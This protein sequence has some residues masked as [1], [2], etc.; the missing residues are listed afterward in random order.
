[1]AVEAVLA[2][3]GIGK[4]FPGVTALD[5]V[6]FDC[7]PGEIHGLVGENGAGKS[8]LMRILAGV[9]PPDAGRILLRGEE[10][11][12][13]GPAEAH[14]LGIAMVYQDTR[15]VPDLD[16]A[17]NIFLGHE[18]GGRLLVDRS[19]MRLRTAAILRRLGLDLDPATRVGDLGLA[20][21]QLVEIGR[22]LAVEAPVLILDEP[23]SSLTPPEVLRLFA[24][25]RELRAEGRSLV[26]ISHRLPEV[27]GLTDRI[28]VLKDG[29]VVATVP[30]AG[31]DAE[32][33]VRLMVGRDTS[34][35]YPPKATRAGPVRL[36]VDG[37]AAGGR[38]ADVRLAVRG[39]EIVGLGG[40]Q[41]SGQQDIA[42]ALGGVL[43]ATGT[44]TLDGRALT[45]R[46]PA[47][48]LAAGIIYVPADRRREGL[49]LPHAVREN[50]AAPHLGRWARL[51]LV[52]RATEA[53]AVARGIAGL[54]IRTPSPEQP[55]ATLSG[56]NQQK[57][58]FA[59]W[60]LAEPKV[61]ILD[62]PTQG[63]DVATKL[64]LY[65]Q[66][67]ALA[68]G[69][70][71][72]VVLSAD[73]LELMGLCDRILVVAR[74]R[75]VDDVPAA[76]ASEERIVGAAVKQADT[77]H[78]A[79]PVQRRRA[80]SPLR[81]R[82]A[83]VALLLLLIVALGAL[84]TSL[85]PWFLTP[86]NL[87]SLAM[88]VTPLALVALG[89]L[90]VILLGGIDL[91]VGPTISLVTA[92]ASFLL[93]S[94][95]GGGTA[96]G[97]AACLATGLAVGLGNA[98]LIRWLRI[99]DLVATLATYSI[100]FGLALIVRPSP[101]GSFDPALAGWITAKWGP[102]PVVAL[103]TLVLFLGLE[104]LLARGRLGPRLYATGGAREAAFVAGIAI[105][106][107]RVA[108]YLACGLFAALAGLV[109]AARI[110]SG[111]PQA[112]ISFTVTSITAVV[113]G[114]VGVAGGRGTALGTLL[115]CILVI[116]MQNVLNQ[117]HVS[118]YWQYVWTGGLLLLAVGVDALRERW[119]AVRG[120]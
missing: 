67:R 33:L 13:A 27:L 7:R 115:G 111:D 31:T 44:V 86:R 112:G 78:G 76:E 5:G 52:D 46:Q 37:L 48:A 98:V 3:E 68:E 30:T 22:A 90:L 17:A 18:P 50:I 105:D 36:A 85:S 75:I 56:G 95:A 9:H 73:V 29:R 15:L 110:G 4:T 57:V 26:F 72:V 120:G 8:T 34:L 55:V 87:G 16:I 113:V 109:V 49:F 119:S 41:G 43:P 6:G 11:R 14:A 12:L 62:E 92:V 10:V 28:T 89:Q 1:M 99:P 74:G 88:Q 47:D 66:I 24:I 103:A 79:G 20:E 64:E 38:F 94:D 60:Q 40:I 39:G 114:G 104:L 51:G 106:R 101:G 19:T 71:A 118:A 108:A 59:R 25:L 84:A 80:L 82:Y 35:A 58:V 107:V 116:L 65:R 102:V 93:A 77:G 70:A 97:L 100:V 69:G 61:Y 42:R 23:T 83:G 81:R 2:V 117:L 54:A 32:Q 91:A 96:L 63:V 45:L 53:A 21:R